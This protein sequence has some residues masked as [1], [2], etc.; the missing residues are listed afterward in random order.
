MRRALSFF[1]QEEKAVA[2]TVLAEEQFLKESL[3][4]RKKP[5]GPT[6][7]DIDDDA[8]AGEA[9]ADKSK[10]R[11]PPRIGSMI[12]GDVED[13]G[14]DEDGVDVAVHGGVVALRRPVASDIRWPRVAATP[15]LPRGYSVA[16]RRGETPRPPR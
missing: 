1:V 3:T 14:E 11:S 6:W 2:S 13:D 16:K 5:A 4:G 12:I 7:G 9:G 15:R 10:R 8:G